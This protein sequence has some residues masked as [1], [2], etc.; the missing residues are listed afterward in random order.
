VDK[1]I[2][3]P[4]GYQPIVDSCG[5]LRINANQKQELLTEFLTGVEN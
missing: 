1:S 5:Y 3:S 2:H 4:V